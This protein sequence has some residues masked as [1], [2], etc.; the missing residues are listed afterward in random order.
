MK[1]VKDLK[2]T[3]IE[4]LVVVAIM[5]ILSSMLLPSISTAKQKSQSAVCIGN[6]KQQGVAIQ[7]YPDDNDG[8]L[9]YAADPNGVPMSYRRL[10]S[11]YTNKTTFI[12]T[13][14]WDPNTWARGYFKGLYLCP[15]AEKD[16]LT[17]AG[18]YGWNEKYLGYQ[19]QNQIRINKIKKPSTTLCAGDSPSKAQKSNWWEWSYIKPTKPSKRHNNGRI[20]NYVM[21]DGS[22]TNFTDYSVQQSSGQFA[23]YWLSA[24]N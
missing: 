5:G 10:L 17:H 6:L 24:Q 15:N 22:A 2:F 23:T 16:V 21:G 3:L 19:I 7:L 18:S 12:Q 14:S 11:A 9:P 4:L 20:A 8:Y 1:L 13:T